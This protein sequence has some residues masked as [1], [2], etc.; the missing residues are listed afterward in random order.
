MQAQALIHIQNEWHYPNSALLR[1]A[2]VCIGA[3]TGANALNEIIRLRFG[4]L[5]TTAA[6]CRTLATA[7]A[8][9]FVIRSLALLRLAVGV[10]LGSRSSS[11]C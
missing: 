7:W 1:A 10:K 2:V 6:K 11:R 9:R 3:T 4:V 8:R 5:T